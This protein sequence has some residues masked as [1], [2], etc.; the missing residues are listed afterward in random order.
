MRALCNREGLLTAFGLVSGVVPARSPKPI[1]Q[2]LKL[3][4][5]AGTKA[6]VWRDDKQI[7]AWSCQ[8]ELDR[9]HPRTVIAVATHISSLKRHLTVVE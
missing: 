8:L 7:T 9:E 6:R 5:D 3:V 2:N 4:A 1:L